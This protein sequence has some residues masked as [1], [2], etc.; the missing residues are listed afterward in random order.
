[1]VD[2]WRE[3]EVKKCTLSREE[4]LANAPKVQDGYV[5]VARVIA[6]D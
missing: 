5:K 3:D 4:L 2:Q 1:L 6:G